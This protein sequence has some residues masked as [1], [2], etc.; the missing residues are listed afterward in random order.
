MNVLIGISS[1]TPQAEKDRDYYGI[2]QFLNLDAAGQ[3]LGSRPLGSQLPEAFS[4]IHQAGK[5]ETE[6]LS[7]QLAG[8]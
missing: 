4:Y 5:M 3:N 6:L 8:M 2:K 1:N 7:L